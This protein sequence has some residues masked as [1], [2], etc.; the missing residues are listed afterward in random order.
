MNPEGGMIF[1]LGLIFGVPLLLGL[2]HLLNWS[3]GRT[4]IP[5]WLPIAAL[6]VLI[7]AGSFYLDTAGEVHTVKV[8]RK[9]ETIKYELGARE[10]PSW[11]RQLSVQ[12]ESPPEPTGDHSLTPFL[13]L[14]ADAN[15]FDVLR[16]GQ[17]TQ[18]RLIEL[19][20]LF[21]FGRFASRSTFSMIAGLFPR[22]PRGPWHE[23][24]AIV[25]QVD[26]VTD[27]VERSPNTRIP[28]RWPYKIVRLSF[29]P[30]GRAEAVEV[31][32]NIE[33]GSV[34]G[35]TEKTVVP[36]IWPEDVPRDARIAGA[37]PGRPWANWFYVM[38]EEL[39]IVTV[40][41]ALLLAFSLWRR[42]AKKT[43]AEE[44]TARV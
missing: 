39:T 1:L 43:K 35:I 6:I 34:N 36:I 24:T 37:R 17:T 4:L 13:S 11:T 27:Y 30:P 25:E 28:L 21:K 22:P 10:G 8:I 29:T 3:V 40:A 44:S 32:D 18:V 16:V 7:V 9:N 41:L 5:L 31:V 26:D 15:T 2:L 38:G 20:R 42:S 33:I 12:V 19:G 14:S 23:A